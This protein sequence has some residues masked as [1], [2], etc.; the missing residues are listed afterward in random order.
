MIFKAQIKDGKLVEKLPYI[1]NL[2]GIVEIE[3]RRPK[4][5]IKQNNALHPWLDQY[6]QMCR[7]EG[8][9]AE[10]LLSEKSDVPVTATFLKDLIRHI[11]KRMFGKEHTS[12]LTTVELSKVCEVF[13]KAMSEK[14]GQFIPFPSKEYDL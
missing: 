3:I 8:I 7:A 9:T 11:A 14:T 6:E 13:Q 10:M 2:E 12:E 4:R 5:T 1:F